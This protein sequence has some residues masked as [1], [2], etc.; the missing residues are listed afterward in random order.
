MASGIGGLRTHK[1]PRCAMKAFLKLV[2]IGKKTIWNQSPSNATIRPFYVF[3]A[4]DEE[5]DKAY[6]AYGTKFAA[7]IEKEKL[8]VV[9]SPGKFE[10]RKNHP[11][12]NCQAWLWHPDQPALERWWDKNATA[13]EKAAG[14]KD[15][16]ELV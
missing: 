9:V 3:T 11:G 10:N 8:G 4:G 12:R 15:E 13:K 16:D 1:S 7:F 6:G 14:G 5:K 2:M